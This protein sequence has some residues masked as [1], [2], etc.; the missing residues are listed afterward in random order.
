LLQNI[1]DVLSKSLIWMIAHNLRHFKDRVPT[2]NCR[3]LN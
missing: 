1:G 3:C 2:K